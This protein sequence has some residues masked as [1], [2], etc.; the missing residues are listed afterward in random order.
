MPLPDL[1]GSLLDPVCAGALVLL[2]LMA[3]V[4]L[5]GRLRIG[6]LVAAGAVLLWWLA[7]FVSIDVSSTMS[8]C[9]TVLT[10]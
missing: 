5:R 7:S 6:G 2:F 9:R 4:F 1:L 10:L 8:A 3:G